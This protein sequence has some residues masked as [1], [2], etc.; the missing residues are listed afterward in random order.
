MKLKIIFIITLS[1]FVVLT[2]ESAIAQQMAQSMGHKFTTG[3]EQVSTCW[4]A[5]PDGVAMESR[6][7]H[8]LSGLTVGLLGGIENTF[9]KLG[10]GVSNVG[11]FMVPPYV[12]EEVEVDYVNGEQYSPVPYYEEKENPSGFRTTF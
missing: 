3:L 8:F 9:G 5:I 10:H 6:E 12:S 4:M 11:L 2:T 1:V 7:S